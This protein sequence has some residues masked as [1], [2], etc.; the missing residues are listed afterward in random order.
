MTKAIVRPK[1]T[2]E[3]ALKRFNEYYDKR[4]KTNLGRYRAKMFDMMYQK[5]K[6]RLLKEDDPKSYK[7]L[8]EE[9]PRTFDFEG[10]D[11]F[12]E[13]KELELEYNGENVKFKSRGSTIY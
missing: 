1:V 8:L 5:N 6:D 4:G 9:G 13:G 2:K 12:P 10:V 7:Y 3:M 11:Y